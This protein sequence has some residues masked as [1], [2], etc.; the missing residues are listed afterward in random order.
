MSLAFALNQAQKWLRNLTI[1]EFDLFLEQ[2]MP[3]LDLILEQ[4]RPGQRII[5]KEHIKLVR[6][7]KPHP[8]SNP[9]YW[10]AF[11]AIGI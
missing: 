6:Q 10:A 1:D 4:L 5:H 3:Q 8:F 7:R 9:Y 11:T 2:F